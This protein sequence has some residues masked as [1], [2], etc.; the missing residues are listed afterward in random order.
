MDHRLIPFTKGKSMKKNIMGKLM[1]KRG[2]IL[3]E[4]LWLVLFSCAFLTVMS[5]LYETGKKE[6]KLSRFFS[7][8]KNNK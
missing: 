6:I 4:A 3:M 5:H 8:E 1:V 7:Q 2:Q